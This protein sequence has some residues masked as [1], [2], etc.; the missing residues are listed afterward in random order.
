MEREVS[1]HI[2]ARLFTLTERGEKQKEFIEETENDGMSVKDD[3]RRRGEWNKNSVLLP[4]LHFILLLFL[5]DFKL[6]H[7]NSS[8]SKSVDRDATILIIMKLEIA[9]FVNVRGN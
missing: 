2:K 9:P 1:I 5:T 3:A 7:F 6:F 8:T 4:L